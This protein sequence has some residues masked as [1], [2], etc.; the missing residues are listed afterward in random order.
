MLS[1]T[2]MRYMPELAIAQFLGMAIF[3]AWAISL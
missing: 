2:I 3:A 1:A